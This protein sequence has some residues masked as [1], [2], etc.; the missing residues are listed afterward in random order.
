MKK[1][2]LVL[3]SALLMTMLSG[4]KEEAPIATLDSEGTE[5]IIVEK[6]IT[7]ERA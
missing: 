7:E 3:V 2:I 1:I 4:C 5:N 6:T